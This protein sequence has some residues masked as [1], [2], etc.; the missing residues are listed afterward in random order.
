MC[1]RRRLRIIFIVTGLPVGGAEFALCRLIKALPSTV[2]PRVICLREMGHVGLEI[3]KLGVVVDCL[4]MNPKYPSPLALF[5]L[6]QMLKKSQ[7]DIVQTWMYHADLF[8]GL[9][10]TM[11]CSGVP[12]VW[13]VRR[14]SLSPRYTK[15]LTIVIAKICAWLSHTIPSAIIFN[16]K[17][18]QNRH[19]H[20]GYLANRTCVIPNGV[21]LTEFRPNPVARLAIRHELDI[22]VGS[23]LVGVIARFDVTKNHVGFIRIAAALHRRMPHCHFLFAGDGV[24]GTNPQLTEEIHSAALGDHVHFLGIRSDIPDLMAALDVLAMPSWAEAFPN[25]LAEAIACGTPCVS[26][27]VGDASYILEGAGFVVPVGDHD[28][29]AL[30]L[31]ELICLPDEDRRAMGVLARARSESL[32][33]VGQMG[34][35]YLA[36]YESL[37]ISRSPTHGSIAH[38]KNDSR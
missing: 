14:F 9:A 18:S 23:P 33:S 37:M 34:S 36:L 6:T 7:P 27:D 5:R 10:A 19:V 8:G 35:R 20:F 12:I 1:E 16:S 24:D 26:T 25:V 3:E 28:K 17:S 13:S 4:G 22:P 21:D 31:E 38:Q 15:F 32:F 30:R 11:A 29:F 2:E